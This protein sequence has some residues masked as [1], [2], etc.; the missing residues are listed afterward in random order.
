MICTVL[1][2][3]SINYAI[4]IAR[5]LFCMPGTLV[6]L[7]VIAQVSPAMFV[8]TTVL[9]VS[10]VSAMKRT[11]IITHRIRRVMTVGNYVHNFDERTVFQLRKECTPA[12]LRAQSEWNPWIM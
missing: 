6:S 9:A 10:I 11:L 4:H 5:I 7:N 1:H 2:G 8:V 3:F 12:V